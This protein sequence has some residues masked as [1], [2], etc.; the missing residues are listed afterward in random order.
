MHVERKQ[1]ADGSEMQ[2]IPMKNFFIVFFLSIAIFLMLIISAPFLVIPIGNLL[3]KESSSYS[4][5]LLCSIL[6]ESVQIIACLGAGIFLGFKKQ[7]NNA[8]S[9]GILT[10]CVSTILYFL[11]WVQIMKLAGYKSLRFTKLYIH[12]QSIIFFL[13]LLA[14]L[15]GVKLGK[16]W[17]K[18]KTFH[19][20]KT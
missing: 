5:A 11:F 3:I 16:I 17:F 10:V 18:R 15:L 6:E 2:K 12:T 1:H 14:V 19:I 13:S 9:L 7:W 4:I 8:K 20:G